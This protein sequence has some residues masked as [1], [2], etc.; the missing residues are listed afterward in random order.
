MI[1]AKK[2][3]K[4]YILPFGRYNDSSDVLSYARGIFMSSIKLKENALGQFIKKK[5]TEQKLEGVEKFAEGICDSGSFRQILSGRRVPKLGSE[6]IKKIADKLNVPF[7]EIEGYQI[8]SMKEKQTL[9]ETS[10]QSKKKATQE[11]LFE[12]L[13]PLPSDN[14]L[15]LG[16]EG[17]RPNN[18]EYIAG[19][20]RLISTK[21]QIL[22]DLFT[23][24]KEQGLSEEEEKKTIFIVFQGEQSIFSIS[25]EYQNEY[26][27]RLADV[28][29]QGWNVKHLIRLDP[30][31]L[32]RTYEIASNS[33]RFLGNQGQYEPRYL[34]TRHIL[35][36]SYGIFMIYGEEGLISLSADEEKMADSAI[37][38]NNKDSLEILYKHCKQFEHRSKPIFKLDSPTYQRP[39]FVQAISEADSRAGDRYI[40]SRRLTEITRPLSWYTKDHPWAQALLK[41]LKETGSEEVDLSNHIE[42]RKERAASLLKYLD[43][44][45]YDCYYIYPK[46]TFD[47]FVDNGLNNPYYF[48]T[49]NELIIEQLEWILGLLKKERY[50]IALVGSDDFPKIKPA[51]CEVQGNHL[52]FMESWEKNQFSNDSH[53]SNY[54]HRSR[55]HLADDPIIVRAFQ[56]RLSQIWQSIDSDSKDKYLN[57]QFIRQKIGEVKRKLGIKVRTH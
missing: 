21:I 4:I 23:K 16:E 38:I 32:E 19:C 6:L 46:S 13:T 44:D 18:G 33:F 22:K 31:F 1:E 24:T 51:F 28:I 40:I 39:D 37:Y 42:T 8:Q 47:N 52:V 27:S 25:K 15:D 29:A 30:N 54:S 41:Y 26:Q 12:P 14:N 48:T 7:D 34:N 43:S 55:W 11:E 56:N 10:T 45:L 49:S 3:Q 17:K 36:P 5:L 35:E 50:H 20:Q 2:E 57:D 53:K 9:R